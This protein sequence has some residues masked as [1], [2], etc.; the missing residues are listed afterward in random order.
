MLPPRPAAR[1]CWNHGMIGRFGSAIRSKL[2]INNQIS[3]TLS[4]VYRSFTVSWTWCRSE[5]QNRFK[6]TTKVAHASI[7]FGAEVAL[8]TAERQRTIPEEEGSRQDAKN[9][10]NAKEGTG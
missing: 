7:V 5:Q 2:A 3:S 9:A 1:Q 10:K 6:G 4:K 8:R